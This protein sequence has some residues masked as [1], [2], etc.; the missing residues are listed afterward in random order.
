MASVASWVA[1]ASV[2]PAATYPASIASSSAS[3]SGRPAR[4]SRLARLARSLRTVGLGRPGMAIVLSMTSRAAG[5]SARLN[6]E[7]I[8]VACSWTATPRSVTVLIR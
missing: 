4:A 2:S 1:W 7:E 8:R 3:G 6:R 5:T